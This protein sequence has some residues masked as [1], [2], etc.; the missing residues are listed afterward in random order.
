MALKKLMQALGLDTGDDEDE[1]TAEMAG[2]T[3]DEMSN[4]RR[5]QNQRGVMVPPPEK[6]AFDGA[7]ANQ[8]GEPQYATDRAASRSMADASRTVE[9][10]NR[11]ERQRAV[12]E[13]TALLGD[14][15]RKYQLPGLFP[16]S[17]QGTEELQ[18]REESEAEP[19]VEALA[20]APRKPMP[21]R[22]GASVAQKEQLAEA[23][24]RASVNPEE[25]STTDQLAAEVGDDEGGGASPEQKAQLA[26]AF[27]RAQNPEGVAAGGESGGPL[28]QVAKMVMGST[29]PRMSGLEKALAERNRLLKLA[30]AE[31]NAGLGADIAGGTNYNARAGE[32]TRARAEAVVDA[33]TRPLEEGRKAAG[34]TR[35]QGDFETRQLD[36][37]QRRRLALSSEERAQ[38]GEGR[39]VAEEGRKQRAFDVNAGRSDPASAVSRNARAEAETLYGAQWNRIPRELRD[40]FTADDVDRLFKE[41][42]AKELAAASGRGA[43][44]IRQS[45]EDDRNL[46]DFEKHL[47]DPGS[48]EAYNRISGRLDDATPIYGMGTTSKMIGGAL[49]AVPVMGKNLQA[50]WAGAFNSL[51]PEGQGL[52]QDAIRVMQDIT[53]QTTG[54]AMNETELANI[55]AR[56]GMA[57]GNEND[58]RNALRDELEAVQLRADRQLSARNPRVQAMARDRGIMPRWRKRGGGARPYALETEGRFNEADAEGR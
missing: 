29:D 30:D 11:H 33:A 9:T 6:P 40:T 12:R 15:A 49:G 41:V 42:S 23:F 36:S 19:V 54:K 21:A 20:A 57:G 22:S 14:V 55:K 43:Q 58:F 4:L 47:V 56:L 37:Q 44:G 3:D 32:G 39:A 52:Y 51:T 46:T 38:A 35:A 50:N 8:Y 17:A 5:E 18:A 34:E 48:V 31:H 10:T 2:L 27:K 26:E 45:I 53:L 28:G 25:Q 24:K 1:V 16:T 13:A 7:F